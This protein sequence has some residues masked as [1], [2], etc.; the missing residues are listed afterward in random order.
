M[1]WTSSSDWK[2][3]AELVEFRRADKDVADELLECIC[4]QS[5]P[6]LATGIVTSLRRARHPRSAIY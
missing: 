6:E 5:P 2:R 1:P 3:L 4:P